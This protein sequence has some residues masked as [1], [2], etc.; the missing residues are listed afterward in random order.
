M[1]VR[2]TKKTVKERLAILADRDPFVDGLL[3]LFASFREASDLAIPMLLS[4]AVDSINLGRGEERVDGRNEGRKCKRSL[5]GRVYFFGRAD[6][7]ACGF[8]LMPIVRNVD[9]RGGRVGS[10]S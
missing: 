8:Y 4:S 9:W 10:W 2:S 1:T 5:V 3:A 7:D 6:G